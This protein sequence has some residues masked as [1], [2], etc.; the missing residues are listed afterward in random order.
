MVLPPESAQKCVQEKEVRFYMVTY[1][2][3]F[4]FSLVLLT[5]LLVAAAFHGRKK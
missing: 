5:A 2:G 1:E 3:L 4:Q